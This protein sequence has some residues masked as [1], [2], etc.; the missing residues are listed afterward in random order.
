M[1]DWLQDNGVYL[2]S[3]SPWGRPAHPMRV[4]S[5]TV[6]DVDVKATAETLQGL[7]A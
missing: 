7:G 1:L 3:Q 2:S 5:A 4:E 6:A